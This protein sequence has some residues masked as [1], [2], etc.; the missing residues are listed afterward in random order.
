MKNKKMIL[1][2]LTVLGS[3]ASCGYSGEEALKD[4]YEE[5]ES[6]TYLGNPNTALLYA[7]D[8]EGESKLAIPFYFVPSKGAYGYDGLVGVTFNKEGFDRGQYDVILGL[9]RD[10]KTYFVGSSYLSKKHEK[11]SQSFYFEQMLTYNGFTLDFDTKKELLNSLVVAVDKGVSYIMES[12]EG[13]VRK[14]FEVLL[15]EF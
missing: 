15:P 12:Y 11:G 1:C 2:S 13:K 7:G 3:L 9:E 6:S 14:A 4:L 10:E 5:T 8:S